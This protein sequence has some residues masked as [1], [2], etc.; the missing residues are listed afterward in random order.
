MRQ[1]G[2]LPDAPDA[3]ALADYLAGM[4]IET[5][6]LQSS[7][8]WELWVCD[9]DKVPRAREEYQA[10]LSNPADERFHRAARSGEVPRESPPARPDA[11]VT[12]RPGAESRRPLTVLLIAA[13][14]LVTVLYNAPRQ[15]NI[16]Y[17]YLF[18]T[19]IHLIGET[20]I[21]WDP[22]LPELRHGELWRVLT[23]AFIHFSPWHILFNMLWLFLLGSQLELRYGTARFAL[24]VVLVAAP[25]HLCQFFFP[26]VALEAGRLVVPPPMPLSGGMS[27]VVYGLFGF[28]WMKAVYEPGCG[29]YV[30]P[31]N[32]VV[33]IVWLIVCMTG[34]IGPVGNTAHLAGLAAGMLSGYVSAWWNGFG[35][36]R[37][38]PESRE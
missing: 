31:T 37:P 23:P 20:H 13:S 19:K 1:I 22:T 8:G 29:L 11:L 4:S 14:I 9:E 18:I 35:S 2:T 32:I 16:V 15:R 34:A 27:G 10:F 5:R 7:G 25:S 17:K 38:P 30:S 12:R 36:G 21:G 6:L 26:A 28:V 3:R 24:L 33:M